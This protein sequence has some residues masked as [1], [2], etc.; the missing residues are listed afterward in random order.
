MSPGLAMGGS[1]ESTKTGGRVG[2]PTGRLVGMNGKIPMGG[3][4]GSTAIAVGIRDLVD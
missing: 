3:S 4:V 2:F 1:V